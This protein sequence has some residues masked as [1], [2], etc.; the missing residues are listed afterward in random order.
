MYLKTTPGSSSTALIQLW[1]QSP[2]LHARKEIPS[3]KQSIIISLAIALCASAAM[4]AQTIH[5]STYDGC[6][7]TGS[8]TRPQEK[9]LNPFKNRDQAPAPSDINKNIKLTGMLMSGE[10]KNRYDNHM[11]AQIT[12]YV[13]SAKVGGIESCNCKAKDLPHRDTHIDIV[14]SPND[15]GSAK[16]HVIVEVTP[17]IRKLM[18]A[19]GKDWSTPTLHQKLPGHLVRFTGWMFYD[20]EHRPQCFNTAPNNPNDWRATAWEIHPVTNIEILK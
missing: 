11:A 6:G 16:R 7:P 5:T 14:L 15:Y 2:K 20:T 13:A 4:H 18:A 1:R 8:A 3:M 19:Q 12:G 10:D 17:R 9:Y